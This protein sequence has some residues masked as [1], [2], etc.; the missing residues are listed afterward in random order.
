MTDYNQTVKRA[1][2]LVPL[3]RATDVMW[4]EGGVGYSRVIAG[5]VVDPGD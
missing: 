2:E 1:I 5:T 3:L 4:H